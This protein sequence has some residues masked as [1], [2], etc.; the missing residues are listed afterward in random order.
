M[1]FRVCE[2]GSTNELIRKSTLAYFEI[3]TKPE[4][5]YLYAH[6]KARIK[7]PLVLNEVVVNPSTLQFLSVGDIFSAIVTNCVVNVCSVR[8]K[9]LNFSLARFNFVTYA[10]VLKEKFAPNKST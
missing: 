1:K 2:L 7:A 10:N 8:V 9:Y 5:S 3:A 6:C 4:L